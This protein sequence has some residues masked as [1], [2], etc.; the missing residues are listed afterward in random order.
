LGTRATL[1]L[2][3]AKDQRLRVVVVRA[4]HR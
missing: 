3:I 2:A 4:R 1:K